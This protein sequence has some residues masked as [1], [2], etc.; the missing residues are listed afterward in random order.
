MLEFLV[1]AFGAACGGGVVGTIVVALVRHQ[2][3]RLSAISEKVDR[4]ERENLVRLE[5][6][7]D[8]HLSLDRPDAVAADLR[9]LSG[10]VSRLSD[11]LMLVA[12]DVAALR[13]VRK[14]R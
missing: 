3:S 2:L 5:K 4:L 1:A 14:G 13:G 10:W 8:D 7:L 6:K 9:N 11:Q 12:D